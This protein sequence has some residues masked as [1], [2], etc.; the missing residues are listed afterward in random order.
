MAAKAKPNLA[1]NLMYKMAAR[2]GKL[3][4]Y[5]MDALRIA[6]GY[7]CRTDAQARKENSGRS[8]GELIESILTHEFED[9][10]LRIDGRE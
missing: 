8:R 5:T 9:D 6:N 7:E 3:S 4:E 2:A 10:A 1:E